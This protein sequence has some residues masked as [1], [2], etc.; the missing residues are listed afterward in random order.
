M[1]HLIRFSP[2]AEMQRLQREIDTLFDGF[3]TPTRGNGDNTHETAWT[4]RVDLAE[5]ENE[6]VIHV[7]VPGLK[8]DDLEI[9]FHDGALA[10]S[11][12]RKFEHTDEGENRKYVRIERSY[13]RFYRSFTLPQAVKHDAIGARFEDGVLTITVPKAEESKPR[14]IEIS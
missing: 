9:N 7:D 5:T 6:Y 10:I 2:S 13:G 12:E 8:K 1:N 3:L 11:G 14:R 4:P